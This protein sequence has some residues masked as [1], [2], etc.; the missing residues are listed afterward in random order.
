MERF[1]W[2]GRGGRVKVEGVGWKGRGGMKE[3]WEIGSN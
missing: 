2:M 3:K 1:K